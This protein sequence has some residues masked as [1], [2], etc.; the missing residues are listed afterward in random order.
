MCV[1][2]LPG[3]VKGVVQAIEKFLEDLAE[4]LEG[5][6]DAWKSPDNAATSPV[7]ARTPRR[8]LE[9]KV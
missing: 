1:V 4:E 7:I 3:F 9:A 2:P 5:C 8:I 6:G